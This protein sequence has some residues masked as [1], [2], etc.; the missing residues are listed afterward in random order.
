VFYTV[1]IEEIH[2]ETDDYLEE[3][4]RR[5]I[6]LKRA[7]HDFS[8]HAGPGNNGYSA[9]EVTREYALSRPRVLFLDEMMYIDEKLEEEPA[10]VLKTIF[11]D[12]DGRYHE[13]V[14]RV[15]TIDKEEL[16]ESMIFSV[17]I[18]YFSLLVA[19]LLVNFIVFHHETRPLHALL[20]WFRSYTIGQRDAL[21]ATRAV[22]SEFKELYRAVESS[23]RKNEEIFEQQKQFISNVAHELQ[24]PLAICKNQLELLAEQESASE[25]QLAGIMTVQ[26][27]L[28]RLVRLN[29]SLLF[30]SRIENGQFIE[31]KE[32]CL[33]DLVKKIA[34][35][36]GEA[37]AYRNI[38]FRVEESDDFRVVMDEMLATSLVTNLLKNAYLHNREN[39]SARVEIRQ[40]ALLF[41]NT[42]SPVALD[43]ERVFKRFYRS[44][45]GEHST[46]LGLAIARSICRGYRLELVYAF[47]EGEH[48]FQVAR[49]L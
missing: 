18:L 12:A 46:G 21:P 35:A 16:Q 14:V 4:A 30:L 42:G 29:R 1:I 48:R 32:I 5:V 13:I 26:E 38:T 28:D 15:P 39:G 37:Y 24:T 41:A 36:F 20:K 2:D 23:T 34:P 40:D 45:A 43:S 44:G 25:K 27:T 3:Y 6:T 49:R 7:G 10:R 8:S 33:N 22:A 47:E 31:M 9:R 11:M 17:L 19:S